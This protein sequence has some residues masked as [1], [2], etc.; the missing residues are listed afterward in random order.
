MANQALSAS[1]DQSLPKPGL[2][3]GLREELAENRL[4]YWLLVPS[5]IGFLIFLIYPI[6][7]MVVTAFST[8]DTL[9]RPTQVGTLQNFVD[10]AN[11]ELM[12]MIIRQTVLF[13]FGTVALEVILAFPLA[14]SIKVILDRLIKV[15][16]VQGDMLSLPAVP[17]RHR[18]SL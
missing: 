10:L 7:N 14:G 5:V 4:A 15:T 11:D 6:G 1:L 8:V 9:G 3:R 13:A 18:N 16:S 12:P 2:W 17:L